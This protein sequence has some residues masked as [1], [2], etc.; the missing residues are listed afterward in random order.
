MIAFLARRNLVRQRARTFLCA[1]GLAVSTALL[2]DMA[3]LASGLKASL[4][5]VLE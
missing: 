3:L 5:H 2:Y 1:L 4:A